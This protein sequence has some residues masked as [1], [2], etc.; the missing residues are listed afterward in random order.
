MTCGPLVPKSSC[1]CGG[2]RI[3]TSRVS[4]LRDAHAT[5][6]VDEGR[7]DHR[8]D[9]S[10]W[11]SPGYQL[12]FVKSRRIRPRVYDSTSSIAGSWTRYSARGALG[13][14]NPG[15]FSGGCRSS[16]QAERRPLDSRR[17]TQGPKFRS[18]YNFACKLEFPII[19]ERSFRKAF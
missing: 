3:T 10:F 2:D 14:R 18:K 9:K 12:R 15:N 7:L 19:L 8:R 13:V 16:Q 4:Q 17:Q 6:L 11:C 1:S 5:Q